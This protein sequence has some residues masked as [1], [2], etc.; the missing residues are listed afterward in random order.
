MGKRIAVAV[1]VLAVISGVL[2]TLNRPQPVVATS[3]T[4]TPTPSPTA[5]PFPVNEVQTPT[6]TPY[7]TEI[8]SHVDPKMPQLLVLERVDSGCILKVTKNGAFQNWTK[9]QWCPEEENF[10]F[11]SGRNRVLFIQGDKYWTVEK[12]LGAEPKV[13]ADAFKSPGAGGSSKTWIDEKTKRLSTARL[14]VVGN[15]QNVPSN[16]A[17]KKTF[18]FLQDTWMTTHE[19]ADGMPSVAVVAQLNETGQWNILSEQRSNCCADITPD[20]EPIREFIHEDKGI[21]SMEELLKKTL[22]GQR[23]CESIEFKPSPETSAWIS[24]TFES[25]QDSPVGYKKM[26]ANDGFIFQTIFGD[27]LHA[28]DP[29]YYCKNNCAEHVLVESLTEIK[30]EAFSSK[31]GFV[32]I[33]EEYSGNHAKVWQSGSPKA[34]IIF[35]RDSVAA[36]LPDDFQF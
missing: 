18:P 16:E 3:V 14:I 24:N 4:P 36:W 19:H 21:L 15:P 31:A 32:I 28:T 26:G 11:D 23:V 12:K 2:F 30:Q 22:C 9:L 1:L 33:S 13:L 7:R 6:P 8:P 25:D 20:F 35:E 10:I 5:T 27:S 34:F 29:V 17:L